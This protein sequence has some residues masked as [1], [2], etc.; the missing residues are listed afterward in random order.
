MDK[1]LKA[2]H[3]DYSDSLMALAGV[4]NVGIGNDCLYVYLEKDTPKIRA[5]IPEKL[6][7]FPV[8]V[9]FIGKIK[10]A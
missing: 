8:L 6:G 4:S 3:T 9:R 10:A 1:D 7:G 2:A 5:A